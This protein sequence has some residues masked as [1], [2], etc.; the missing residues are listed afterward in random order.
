MNIPIVVIA[1]NRSHSLKRI[2]QSIDAAHFDYKK[3]DL[4]IS[5]DKGDNNRV[6]D[7]AEE[8]NWQYGDKIVIKH[9]KNLGLK[10]HVLSCGDLT[11]DYDAI[12]MLEDDLV[13]SKS[14]YRYAT[15]SVDYYKNDKGVGGISLYTYGIS[16]FSNFRTFIPMQDDS[17]IFFMNVPSSWGQIWTKSQWDLFRDWYNKKEYQKNNYK[18]V[19]PQV[20]MNWGE[21][22]WKKYFFMYIAEK[23]KYIVYPRVGLSTNMSDIGTHRMITCTDH[24]SILMGNFNRKYI[25]KSL[26]DSECVYDSFF[27]NVNLSHMINLSDEITIDYY[28]LKTFPYITRYLLSTRNLNYKI[29]QSWSLALKPYELNILYDLEGNDIFLYDLKSRGKDIENNKLN[30]NIIK[31]DLPGLTKEKA[32]Q[33]VKIEY[34]AA[35]KRK[36][37]SFL[38]K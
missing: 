11:K 26:D 31:Y 15:Q 7:I 13:V 30:S 2:L 17:D 29:K 19:I 33:I 21:A 16:E 35:V 24:Q 38:N 14:F 10:E 8:F 37:R 23:K 32:L 1:Y 25:F 36:I 4:I 27:E 5:I 9:E 20:V 28:G 12:I 18:G 34:K 6:Y 22:S 3:V